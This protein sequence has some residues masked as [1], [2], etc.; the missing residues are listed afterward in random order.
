MF[1]TRA[2]LMFTMAGGFLKGVFASYNQ[3][4]D[5]ETLQALIDSE[6][7][8]VRLGNSELAFLSGHSIKHQQ[9]ESVLRR[10]LM[11]LLTS[12]SERYLLALPVDTT[13]KP[14]L[15]GRKFDPKVWGFTT[16]YVMRS[17]IRSRCYGSPF[18]F[19]MKDVVEHEREWCKENLP[20]L[21][22][23]YDVIYVGPRAG[24]NK[25]I[26]GGIKPRKKIYIPEVNAFDNYDTLFREL[27]VSAK[28]LDNPLVV[29]VGGITASVLAGELSLQGVRSIDLGQMSRHMAS[30]S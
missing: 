12:P 11:A 4:S 25:E 7:G 28:R 13:L 19:R 15:N 16:R 27:L 29:V 10:K 9:Y 1:V 3:L 30:T 5:Q 21:F 26:W 2:W 18:V 20:R 8:L 23:N 22:S 14:G 24:K 6:L 17:I